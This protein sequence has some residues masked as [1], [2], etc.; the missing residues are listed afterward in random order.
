MDKLAELKAIV[1]ELGNRA[2]EYEQ[3]KKAA[4][5]SI[6]DA[7]DALIAGGHIQVHE[8]EAAASELLDHSTCVQLIARLAASQEPTGMSIDRNRKSAS[9]SQS[10]NIL[11]DAPV[12]NYDNTESGTKFKQAFGL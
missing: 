9:V 4:A 3:Q 11:V 6:S 12:R 10:R 1:K 7:V 2:V 8:K 5:D